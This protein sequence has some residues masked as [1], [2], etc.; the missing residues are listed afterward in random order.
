VLFFLFFFYFCTIFALFFKSPK[1]NTVKSKNK[2]TERSEIVSDFAEHKLKAEVEDEKK[3]DTI[4]VLAGVPLRTT[5]LADAIHPLCGGVVVFSIPPGCSTVYLLL[6]QESND[7]WSSFSGHVNDN[8]TAPLGAAREF[9]EECLSVVDVVNLGETAGENLNY[10]QRMTSL[11]QSRR[12]FLRLEIAFQRAEQI[13]V[14]Y[15]KQVPWQ[16]AVCD[17]FDRL[18]SL[19]KQSTASQS[20]L[21]DDLKSHPAIKSVDPVVELHSHYFEKTRIAWFSLERLQQSIRN[22]G[23]YKDERF[24]PVFLPALQLIVQK[25]TECVKEERQK[26]Q[27]VRPIRLSQG[28]YD[29]FSFHGDLG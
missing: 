20:P 2:M 3:N 15:V 26:M 23:R 22:G 10:Q 25:L 24:H 27:K 29:R 8:E 6:G 18:R 16:A 13:R 7:F 28:R 12:Y 4:N 17:R 5:L 11:L 21:P 14:F 1:K 19:F 9:S